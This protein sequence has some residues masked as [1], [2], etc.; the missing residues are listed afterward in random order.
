MRDEIEAKI[1]ENVVRFDK[2]VCLN[3]KNIDDCLI[4]KKPEFDCI[5]NKLETDIKNDES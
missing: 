5:A 4:T 1:N 2:K 3:S